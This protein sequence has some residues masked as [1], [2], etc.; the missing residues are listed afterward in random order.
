MG[1]IEVDQHTSWEDPNFCL[2]RTFLRQWGRLLFGAIAL[3]VTMK[4]WQSTSL[5]SETSGKYRHE[6]QPRLKV[7]E[8]GTSGDSSR[9]AWRY[10][11][12][13]EGTDEGMLYFLILQSNCCKFKQDSLTTVGNN[14]FI[15]TF[16]SI[17]L[18]MNIKNSHF[19][20]TW[21]PTTT[22]R[23]FWMYFL[24]LTKWC[25]KGLLWMQSLNY[26]I[27]F[28]QWR[29]WEFPLCIYKILRNRL[30]LILVFGF[31]AEI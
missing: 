10:K 31:P 28:I 20:R 23:L 17:L 19:Y 30:W 8:W 4:R 14:H 29:K 11:G 13:I 18:T 5:R 12:R 3:E 1:Y 16:L 27:P 24:T 2:T 26:L 15:L 9:N 7:G 6:P 25:C 21:N 22:P